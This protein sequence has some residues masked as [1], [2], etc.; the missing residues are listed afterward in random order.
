MTRL[1]GDKRQKKLRAARLKA[2]GSFSCGDDL[3]RIAKFS[4]EA[5]VIVVS[6]APVQRKAEYPGWCAARAKCRCNRGRQRAGPHFVTVRISVSAD[7]VDR[8]FGFVSSKPLT[9][10][11]LLAFDTW[12]H[13]RNRPPTE[14]LRLR[15]GCAGQRNPRFTNSSNQLRPPSVA[16]K[17]CPD[18]LPPW[19]FAAGVTPPTED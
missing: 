2:P 15:R 7:A 14:R 8:G 16:V 4:F 13:V 6:S 10:L 12:D 5:C 19:R 1:R 3:K 17:G 18:P 11:I 9:M